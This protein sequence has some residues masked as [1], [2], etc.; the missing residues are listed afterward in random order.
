MQSSPSH[1][2]P[3]RDSL[4]TLLSRIDGANLQ[5]LF[6]APWFNE[7][8]PDAALMVGC[9]QGNVAHLEG[10]VAVHTGKVFDAI[11]RGAQARLGRSAD[12][13]ERLAAVLHDCRKPAT[14]L[15]RGDGR[16]NFPG[17]EALAA[18]LVP[19]IADKLGLTAEEGARLEF[20]VRNHGTVHHWPTLPDTTKAELKSSPFFTTLTLLQEADAVSNLLPGGGHLPVYWDAMTRLLP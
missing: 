8:I 6:T 12:F 19:S 7:L 14:R 5:R 2:S 11:E 1:F 18:D 10:D 16:V 17:H 13:I 9:G 20:V 3:N 15:D 4:A